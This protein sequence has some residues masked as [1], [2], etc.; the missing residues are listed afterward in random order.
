MVT[1]V[2]S[3]IVP[4]HFMASSNIFSDVITIIN[5][6][7]CLITITVIIITINYLLKHVPS[8]YV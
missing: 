1:A 2:T 3:F 7:V 5:V 6:S 8:N 4:R